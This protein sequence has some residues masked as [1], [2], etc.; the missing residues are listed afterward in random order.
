MG[1]VR[2]PSGEFVALPDSI[3]PGNIAAIAP[4]PVAAIQQP[5]YTTKLSP[6]EEKKFQAWVKQNKVPFDP[7]P[8]ADYD[9]RGFYKALQSKDP[10][11]ITAI[12]PADQQM[13]FPDVWK[14]PY[15]ATFS[16]ESKY[17]AP[18]APEWQ[19]DRLVSPNGMVIADETPAPE[20]IPTGA[21]SPGQLPPS[22]LHY[23]SGGKLGE[24]DTVTHPLPMAISGASLG[25]AI[26]TPRTPV[27]VP[28]A[29]QP[30]VV[31][32]IPAPLPPAT[33]VEGRLAT[34]DNGDKKSRD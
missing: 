26:G 17:A 7:S 24:P 32:G 11:A 33:D 22:V 9:M 1:V 2:L 20:P 15:H 31:S 18:G 28:V 34:I 8:E 5:S 29:P 23:L 21:L 14:T 19:G 10:R 25:G 30:I 3:T 12:N 4:R 16:N 27:A 6:D 13:H